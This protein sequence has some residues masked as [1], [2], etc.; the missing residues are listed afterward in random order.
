MSSPSTPVNMQKIATP[1]APKKAK[2]EPT[3]EQIAAKEAKAAAKAKKLEEKEATKEATKA[4]K[5]EEKAAK[6]SES[7]TD[8]VIKKKIAAVKKA[9][10]AITKPN[11][12][13]DLLA[14]LI[15]V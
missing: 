15:L 4:K 3:T 2:K 5:L 6:R 14:D 13:G 8:V 10:K 9:K 11:A 1:L 7:G 12:S